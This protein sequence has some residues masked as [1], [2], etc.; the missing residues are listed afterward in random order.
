[1][2]EEV[3]WHFKRMRGRST[4][5]QVDTPGQTTYSIDLCTLYAV[6]GRSPS[7]CDGGRLNGGKIGESGGNNDSGSGS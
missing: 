3:K 4:I 2:A 5:C 1:M 6:A 7:K